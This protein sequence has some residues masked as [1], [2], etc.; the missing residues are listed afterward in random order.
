MRKSKHT[1]WS[2]SRGSLGA[3]HWFAGL[4]T[5]A[6]VVSVLAP[7]AKAEKVLRVGL[8]SMPPFKANAYSGNG[9]PGV[10]LWN[11]LFDTLTDIDGTGTV[12]PM[13]AERWENIDPTT[14]RFS[15]R[16]NVKFHNGENVTAKAITDAITFLIDNEGKLSVSRNIR[17]AGIV[18]AT[19]VDDLTVEIKTS[20]PNPIV[21]TQLAILPIFEPGQVARIGVDKFALDPIGTGSFKLDKWTPNGVDLVRHESYWRGTPNIERIV[22][23]E[24]PEGPARVLALNSDQIDIDIAV[25]ADAFASVTEAGGTIDASPAP[26]VMGISLISGGQKDGRG[27]TTPFADKRVRRA[28]NLA[29]D[30]QSI[31]DN[32]LGGIGRPGTSAATAA[33]FGFNSDLKPYPYDPAGA[34]RLLQEAG[35]GDGFDL[36]VTATVTDPSLKLMYEQAVNDINRNTP[37]RAEL[38]AITFA[39]WLQNWQQGTWPGDAFGFGYFLAPEMDGASSFNFASCNKKPEV[40][41]YYCDEGERALLAKANAEFDPAKRKVILQDLLKLHYENSPILVLIE[42]QDTMGVG[43]RVRNFKNVNLKLNYFEM[44]VAN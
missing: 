16:P 44:D 26:R 36:K 31:I 10:F 38:I 25:Q 6:L 9:P 41:I 30:R 1:L 7:S 4:V 3:V 28:V 11:A 39:V 2:M 15:I 22:M 37:I 20:R 32:L 29:V 23:L 5:L 35:Y 18:S 21:P 19:A 42:T 12:Q 34:R 14:W 13:V 33:T 17:N 40:S 8:Q 43:H 24:I 27:K